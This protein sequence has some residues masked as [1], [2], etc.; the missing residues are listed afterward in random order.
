M[1]HHWPA[2]FEL[3]QQLGLLAHSNSR[4]GRSHGNGSDAGGQAG[5]S[6]GLE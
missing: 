3:A 2:R 6:G 1:G 5:L 4:G